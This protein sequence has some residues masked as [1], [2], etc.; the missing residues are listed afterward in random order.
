MKNS[1]IAKVVGLTLGLALAGAPRAASAAG[2]GDLNN[3]GQV[4]IVDVVRMANC[5]AGLCNEA[6][7]CGGAGL[8][9]C[10]DT[11]GD[12]SVGVAQT[13]DLDQLVRKVAGLESLHDMC[14]PVG[15]DISCPGGTVTLTSGTISSS[16][17]WPASCLVKLAG[18]VLVDS[19]TGG[20]T[21]VLTIEAGATVEG[22][23]GTVDP[24]TLI[25]LPGAKISAI[26]S[27]ANP[28]VFTSDQPAG[29]RAKGDWGGLMLNGQSTVNRPNCTNAAEG[30]P[31]SYG[32]CDANDSSGA[33]RYVRVE[34]A[35]RLFTPNNELNNF[36][37]NGIGRG[38]DISYVHS[39]VGADDCIE[40]FGGTVNSNHMVASGCADDAFDWQLGFTGSMQYGLYI[41]NGQLTDAGAR[42]SRGIEADNSEFGNNDLPR[43]NPAMCNLT[44]VSARSQSGGDNGGSDSGIL[45]RRGTAGQVANVIVTGF[46]D[47]GVELRDVSTTQV[48]CINDDPNTPPESLTGSLLVQS[49][50][51][52]ENGDFPGAGTEQAKT[53]AIAGGNCSTPQWYALLP[54]VTADGANPVNPN[55]STEYPAANTLFDARPSAP[56]TGAPTAADCT[57]L[58]DVFE[59]APYIGA[60]DPNGPAN[61]WL[62]T[63]WNNF[64]VN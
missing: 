47:A 60:M 8:A 53:G 51:F 62:S 23:K 56:I 33:L 38:T 21:T 16:Q 64:N 18:T 7:E 49:A 4:T 1:R 34:Y 30:V 43:S 61:G 41:A 25:V 17:R 10:G 29:S 48:A 36:T 22:V 46:Q 57:L 12:G 20:P 27:A 35:G 14:A 26:G 3:D 52:Y 59:S 54:N 5:V 45:F 40:W 28:I 6:T 13:D 55:I 37:M 50:I 9:T 11:Y 63:P 42:D 44:L 31:E 32:G 19:P 39:N 24:A 2:C 15:A 58:S